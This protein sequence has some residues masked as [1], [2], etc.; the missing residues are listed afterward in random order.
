MHRQILIVGRSVN[1][2]LHFFFEEREREREKKFKFEIFFPIIFYRF[3]HH[4]IT[5]YA[6]FED[7]HAADGLPLSLSPSLPLSLQV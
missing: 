2:H 6:N 3:G 1:H 4:E 7:R 5:S